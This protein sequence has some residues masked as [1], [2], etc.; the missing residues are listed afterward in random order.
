MGVCGFDIA[1]VSLETEA[2]GVLFGASRSALAFDRCLG[3]TGNGVVEEMFC[4]GRREEDRANGLGLVSLGF[5]E[6]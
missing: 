4:R 2:A 3:L 6:D 1:C 5:A